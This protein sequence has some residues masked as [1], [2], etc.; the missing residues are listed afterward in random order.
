MRPFWNSDIKAGSVLLHGLDAAPRYWGSIPAVPFEVGRSPL[1]RSYDI[2]I[3]GAGLT[4]A[5]LAERL[6]HRGR[7][8]LVIDRRM[9]A[10]AGT[11]ASTAILTPGLQCGLAALAD[12]VGDAAAERLWHRTEQAI[13]RLLALIGG[14]GIDC[15]LTRTR[16][17]Q[18]AGTAEEADRLAAEAIR[19]TQAGIRTQFLSSR[20]L[21]A[22]YG[23]QSD[24][25][26]LVPVGATLNPVELAAGL[27]A[28]ASRRGTEIVANV[29]VLEARQSGGRVHLLTSEG[30]FLSAGEAIFCTGSDSPDAPAPP[31]TAQVPVTSIVSRPGLS[32]PDWLDRCVLRQG[33][34]EELGLRT[35][36]D[37]RIIAH[38][39]EV[40]GNALDWTENPPATDRV[41]RLASDVSTLLGIDIDEPDWCW[42]DRMTS[43][44]LGLPQVAPLADVPQAHLIHGYGT[45]GIVLGE[46]AAE[47]MMSTLDGH[48]DPDQALFKPA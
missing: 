36:V 47:I 2:V 13:E 12:R 43:L 7:S 25:G 4:G 6:S 38:R 37:G 41:E 27:L 28:R 18:L 17:L 24:G 30:D 20:Q 42:T 23:L 31:A 21:L 5:L 19:R 46:I 16:S 26:L 1:A 29:E 44:P 10:S 32:L 39:L 22:Q 8:V 3:V 48:D 11:A 40:G 9:P 14:L 35:T 34:P 33:S 45:N 15:S